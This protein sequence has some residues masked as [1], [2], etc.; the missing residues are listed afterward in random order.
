M[1]LLGEGK[2]H[3]FLKVVPSAVYGYKSTA[4]SS[5]KVFRDDL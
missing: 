1:T 2:F 5:K 4:G 3:V